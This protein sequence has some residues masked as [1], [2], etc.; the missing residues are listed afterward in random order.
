MTDATLPRVRTLAE[1]AATPPAPRLSRVFRALLQHKDLLVGSL[2]VGTIAFAAIAAPLLAR[3]SISSV[4]LMARLKPPFWLSGG[5]PG[6]LFGTDQLGRDIFTRLLYGA[7]TSLT[8]A[9]LSVGFTSLIGVTV[10]TCA[11]FFGGVVDSILMRMVDLFLAFPGIIVTVVVLSFLGSGI[12]NII[13]VLAVTQWVV[14]ARLVR[15][16]TLS[17]KQRE[18]IESARASGSTNTR[19]IT[20]H[21]LPN[22]ITP[23]GVL[24]SLQVASMILLEASLSFLGFGVQPPTASWG[25][26]VADGRQ[27]LDNAWW[28][29]TV[30]GVAI[31]VTVLGTKLLSDGLASALDPRSRR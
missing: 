24:A 26:M 4:N 11:G 3:E 23:I 20:R 5:Q 21:I 6:S 22:C 30:P 25:V 28:I 7:R 12:R 14:Y 2:I 31:V 18:F 17:L 13:L 16:L 9:L 1:R 15:G 27:Y 19:I 29:S 8:V 10:G